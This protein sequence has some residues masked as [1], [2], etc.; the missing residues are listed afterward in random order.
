MTNQCPLDY[1]KCENA[2]SCVGKPQNLQ[3]GINYY[4]GYC[5]TDKN[6]PTPPPKDY[7]PCWG[8][9]ICGK[10]QICL[11][12][13]VGY[14]GLAKDPAKFTQYFDPVCG[15]DADCGHFQKNGYCTTNSATK[16]C[17]IDGKTCPNNKCAAQTCVSGKCSID[18]K[19]CTKS[20]DCAAQKC[21]APTPAQFAACWGN[22]HDKCPKTACQW[23]STGMDKRT[24][25][26]HQPNQPNAGTP[27]GSPHIGKTC[28]DLVTEM[29]SDVASCANGYTLTAKGGYDPTKTGPTPPCVFE[30][31]P[32][33]DKWRCNAA[34]SCVSDPLGTYSSQ[35]S[36]KADCTKTT[37]S[38][39]NNTALIIILVIIGVLIL[40]V[41]GFLIYDT[42]MTK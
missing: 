26:Y 35:T 36:C 11:T 4:P 12:K 31:T 33:P 29:G 39:G 1:G 13:K 20:A 16:V 28:N 18:R 9:K 3:C 15:E 19:T 42:T 24:K 22:S 2:W 30:C 32:N 7:T 37:P 41:G 27:T 25:C 40:G 10:K 17:S 14:C 5:G 34:G 23:M 21:G 6:S 38:R 8:D